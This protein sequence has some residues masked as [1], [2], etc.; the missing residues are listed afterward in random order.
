MV[1]DWKEHIPMEEAWS[2]LKETFSRIKRKRDLSVDVC[3]NYILAEDI[4]SRRNVPHFSASAVDGYALATKKTATASIATP[5]HLAQSEYEWVN[6]GAEVPLQ[7]DGVLMIE[8]SSLEDKNLVVYKTL[9]TGDNIRPVGEDVASGQIIAREG[10]YISPPLAALFLAAGYSSVPVWDVPKTL[11]IPTGD[12]IVSGVDWLR[13]GAVSGKVVESNST[14]LKGYFYR[15]GFPLDIVEPLPDDPKFIRDTVLQNVEKYDL[16]LIGA[17]SAKGKKD[18]TSQILSEEGKMLFHWLLM[19]PG[20]PAM[21]ANVKGTPIIDLPGFPMSTAVVAWSL[22]YPLLKLLSEGD[23]DENIVLKEALNAKEE[24]ME[25]LA[26]CSS[27]P[28]RN[29]WLRVKAVSLHGKKKFFPLSSGSSTMWAMSE[30][31]GFVLLSR[32]VAECPIGT[33]LVV[34]LTRKIDWNRR[35]LFQGSNDPAFERLGSYIRRRGGELVYRSVGSLGGLS[36]LSRGECHIAACHLL[37]PDNGTYNDSYIEKLSQ[38]KTWIRRLLFFRQQGLL[39]KK[40]N[41]LE[42]FDIK[43]IA[44]KQA[45]FINRQPGAGTRVLFDALL[46]ENGMKTKEING[47]TIQ[48]TTH[49]DAANRITAGVADVALGIKAAADALNLDF[50]P[51]TEEPYELVYPAEY[52]NHPCLLALLDALNDS[53]WK[54]QVEELGGY[55]WNS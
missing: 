29:E 42:I 20:R 34:W 46:R 45:R 11:F 54:L 4:C 33:E 37:D 16:I 36:A 25:L 7:Y 1:K 15:W 41:P 50:I 2:I 44:E 6:T 23:F 30:A 31:D 26:P 47:Y 17:G 8:D 35:L 3:T 28:G 48:A 13:K 18:Y 43:D 21:A 55:R 52:E 27:V 12:E 5:V 10:D 22:V 40:G 39:V 49:F 9:S 14:M 53:Q 32:S 51:I 38:G 24:I 19:K